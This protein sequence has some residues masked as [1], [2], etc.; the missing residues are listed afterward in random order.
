MQSF[1]LKFQILE[2]FVLVIAVGLEKVSEVIDSFGDFFVHFVEF[3][4]GGFFEFFELEL[5]LILLFALDFKGFF[6]VVDG[7]LNE[8]DGV[9]RF[10]QLVT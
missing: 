8:R 2:L 5:E 7:D 3:C 10:R 6:K 9:L 1:V 4:F